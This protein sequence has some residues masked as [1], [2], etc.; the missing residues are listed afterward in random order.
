MT[1][2]RAVSTFENAFKSSGLI[3]VLFARG[4]AEQGSF[5]CCGVTGELEGSNVGLG[6]KRKVD[7]GF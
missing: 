5:A 4:E 2:Q 1:M 3:A 7:L 6:L